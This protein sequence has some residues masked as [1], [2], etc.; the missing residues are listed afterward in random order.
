[1]LV[2]QLR[3]ELRKLM[4]PLLVGTILTVA[5]VA[6]YLEAANAL[7]DAGGTEYPA[8]SALEPLGAVWIASL[9]MASA[10]GFVI[11]G[12]TAALAFATEL[13]DATLSVAFVMEPRR[14]RLALL[15]LVA[16]LAVL[17]C[18]VIVIASVLIVGSHVVVALGG[19]VTRA[20]P[21][22]LGGAAEHLS[23]AV[24]VIV[25]VAGWSATCALALR[26]EVAG[27]TAVVVS[28]V[29]PLLILDV[30]YL[31]KAFPARWVVDWMHF[32]AF[33]RNIHYLALYDG[34]PLSDQLAVSLLLGASFAT[35]FAVVLTFRQLDVE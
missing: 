3:A 16:V 6:L 2:R 8:P 26:S 1:V 9:Q 15:K 24:V 7:P 21:A 29:A 33:G 20:A 28:F 10:L 11:G 31:G 30:P 27:L 25:V 13:S 19:H 17:L 4:H 18:S 34:H 5:L 12:L 23:R 22:G 14:A 35:W 32:D